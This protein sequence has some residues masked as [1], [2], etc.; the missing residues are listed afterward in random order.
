MPIDTTMTTPVDTT[1]VK[2]AQGLYT[3]ANGASTAKKS[4]DNETFMTLLVAQLKY[5]DPSSPMDTTEMMAQT[6]QLA[7]MEK[8]TT[9]TDT[10]AESFALQMRDA[11]ATLLGKQVSYTQAD[12][13]VK[14]GVAQ[15][16]SYKYSVP[17]VV[18]DGVEVTLD[19]VQT[20][21]TAGSAPVVPPAPTTPADPDDDTTAP[22]T[23]TA[24]ATASA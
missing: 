24:P 9:M 11:A 6:T 21:Q 23:P 22:G 20:V 18:V 13:T 3:G 14:T 19:A 5:Q 10:I 16:V 4:L 7:S 2:N 17:M 1:S 12:G 8:L 15:S